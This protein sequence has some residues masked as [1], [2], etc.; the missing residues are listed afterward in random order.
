MLALY[1]VQNTTINIEFGRFFSAAE[2]G[3]CCTRDWMSVRP[4]QKVL[5]NHGDVD[6]A[7]KGKLH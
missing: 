2:Y 1:G 5:V 3:T 4:R 6:D 7:T